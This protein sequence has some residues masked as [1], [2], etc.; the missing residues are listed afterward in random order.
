MAENCAFSQ[1]RDA[2]GQLTL[3]SSN[4]YNYSTNAPG[5][6]LLQADGN[7]SGSGMASNLFVGNGYQLQWRHDAATRY[8]NNWD[9]ASGGSSYTV[10]LRC[11]DNCDSDS[12]TSQ[13]QR[14]QAAGS[15]LSS[16]VT[17]YITVT[18]AMLA[19]GSW[20][21]EV[22][23]SN[24]DNNCKISIDHKHNGEYVSMII[25]PAC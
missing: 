11:A 16:G 3:A 22:R 19:M 1:I 15:L 20:V 10:Y 17:N 24:S 2:Q 25:R 4:S 8:A 18:E 12:S 6:Q 5:V 9:V 23:I 7:T 21:T 13:D 14:V